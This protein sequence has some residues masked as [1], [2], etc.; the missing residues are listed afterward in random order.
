[1]SAPN[2]KDKKFYK[3]INT[4]YKNYT[5]PKKKKTFNQI[6]Y[7]KEFKLQPQQKFLSKYINPKTAYKGVLVFHRIGAGKTC[8]AVRI[9]ETWKK[10]KK[11]VV[12]TPASLKGNFREELRS[13]CAKDEYLSNAER[14][15][16]DKL[17]PSTK[18]YKK[19]IE[20]SDK[21]IDKYYEV[22][23]YNK[24]VELAEEG[25]ITLRN[26]IL[27]V[28]EVQNMVSEDGKYYNVLYDTIHAAPANLRV[29]LLS[30]TPMFDKPVEIALTM[31]LLRLP[32]EF[33]TGRDFDKM[34]IKTKKRKNKIIYDAKNLDLYKSMI[35]G[36]VSYYRGAPPYVFPET[37]IR[38]VKCEM[39]DFQ[40][41][42]YLTVLQSEFK[43]SNSKENKKKLKAFKKG[44]I[45]KLPNN[46]F[47]GTRIISNIAFPNKGINEE[48]FDSFKGRHLKME[49]LMDYSIKF[50]TILRK[51]K[52]ST[53]PVFVYSNFKEYGG[54]KSF[55]KV[56]EYHGYK[57]Y[58][59][60]KD[61]RRRFSIWSGN[62]KQ[63]LRDE[64]K[65]V[66]NQPN[67]WNGSKI[68]I[69]IASSAAKE[70]ISLKNMRQVHILEPYWNRSLIK[71]V[72]GRSVRYCSHKG[73]P[74]ENRNVKIF[75][76]LAVH[77]DERITIDQHI[78]KMALRK[79]NLIEQ[80]EMATKEAAIDCTLF[81][82][83]NV[84]KGEED[85]VCEI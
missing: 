60:H 9:G 81:K 51:I 42:S 31:N 48:G 10:H 16:L 40:Y 43:S 17:H 44:N 41:R 55:V 82:N 83:A 19:I 37:K 76:Y 5:I 52:Y 30:A 58:A 70:G 54:I 38:Y 45:L 53:G 46:F 29:V 57:N 49:N 24:F 62:E 6:C 21:R 11:I 78:Q 39:S 73:V 64:I 72:I 25:I 68:K 69:F 26:S 1:M 7:P 22:Y 61:G 18:E 32:K 12:V 84:Y 8:T 36:F 13:L 35:K 20:K 80:F 77:P 23:S 67:N 79:N 66:F 74:E 65:A 75:I 33:P 28:D 63:S 4:K 14:T 15:K 2:I 34:F 85:V 27:I 71:Q 3:K 59:K 50:Y 47:I 56:L